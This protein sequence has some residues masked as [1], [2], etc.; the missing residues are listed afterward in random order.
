[1]PKGLNIDILYTHIECIFGKYFLDA[2]AAQRRI[3]PVRKQGGFW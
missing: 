1:M 3:K 2:S